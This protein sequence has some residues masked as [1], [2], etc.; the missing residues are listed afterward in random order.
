MQQIS[1]DKFDCFLRATTEFT[2]CVLARYGLRDH[3]PARPTLTPPI[4]F[5]Y[6]GSR[7]CSTLPSDPA[8]RRRP[9]ASLSLLLYQDVKRTFTS[10]LSNMLGVPKKTG[11]SSRSRRPFSDPNS[12]SGGFLY[13]G[14]LRSF[15]S[16]DYFKF[17]WITLLQCPVA[18]P[19]YRRV[20][21]EDIRPI[22]AANESVSF[23]IIEPLYCSVHFVSPLDGDS[24]GGDCKAPPRAR[25]A[26]SVSKWNH[27]SRPQS[28]FSFRPVHIYTHLNRLNSSN[29]PSLPQK[30]KVIQYPH[31]RFC[32]L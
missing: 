12:L 29:R 31:N 14:C 30:S 20:V 2:L 24:G 4:R 25:I 17:D 7:I 32:V 6:I 28:Y 10:K 15:G 23:R 18:V 13:L 3:W 16:L 9:C 22:L 26:R 5:L 27:E 1:R 19:G 11:E 8:S 21:Y